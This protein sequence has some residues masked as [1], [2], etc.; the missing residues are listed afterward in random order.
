MGERT[1]L[2]VRAASRSLFFLAEP[3]RPSVLPSALSVVFFFGGFR[4]SKRCAM[5][6]G[7]PIFCASSNLAIAQ[8]LSA[9]TPTPCCKPTRAM[10]AEE[11]SPG[12]L[13][14]SLSLSSK[15]AHQLRCIYV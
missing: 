3:K 4:A 12:V 2:I 11:V 13:S 10:V 15:R 9:A 6:S 1:G 5:A 14:L 7:C 8:A